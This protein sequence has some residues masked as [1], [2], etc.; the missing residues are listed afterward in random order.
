MCSKY[1][2]EKNNVTKIAVSKTISILIWLRGKKYIKNLT[3]FKE[4][5]MLSTELSAVCNNST[6][7]CVWTNGISIYNNSPSYS[8][9]LR[10]SEIIIKKS[11]HIHVAK[12]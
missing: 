1:L 4:I 5:L 2:W 3:G 7:L 10:H 6:M 12:I 8:M 11:A 9:H